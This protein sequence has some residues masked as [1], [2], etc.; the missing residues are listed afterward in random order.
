[1][2]LK[3]LRTGRFLHHMVQDMFYIIYQGVKTNTKTHIQRRSGHE[4]LL[5]RRK[6]AAETPG[7]V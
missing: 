4:Q 3:N 2:L 5:M 1:M 7:Q 6:M